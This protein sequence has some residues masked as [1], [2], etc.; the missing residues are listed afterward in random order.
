MLHSITYLLTPLVVSS[1]C[2][3]QSNSSIA[4]SQP[5]DSA[6][7][8]SMF[9]SISCSCTTTTTR[10]T[11][12]SKLFADTQQN[13]SA[14]TDHA[15][16][17]NHVI[18]WQDVT[19]QFKVRFMTDRSWTWPRYSMDQGGSGDT[20][21]EDTGYEQR[22]W[23]TFPITGLWLHSSPELT[24]HYP[25]KSRLIFKKGNS[26]CRNVNQIIIRFETVNFYI[27]ILE[28]RYNF[29]T[30]DLWTKP[31]SLSHWSA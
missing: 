5:H 10:T 21:D 8:G 28:L 20:Q 19:V 1:F 4:S 24:R 16:R 27:I 23:F 26:G 7:A 18:N 6:T 11:R 31:I 25:E 2:H 9:I 30:A 15:L 3:F 13:K 14:I 17:E 22:H 12:K 29:H